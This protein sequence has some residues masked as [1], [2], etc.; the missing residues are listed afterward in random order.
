MLTFKKTLNFLK[1]FLFGFVILTCFLACD[2][3]PVDPLVIVDTD[4]DGIP[5]ATD[6]CPEIFNP[7][8]EDL[9][10]NGI[11]DACEDIVNNDLDDDGILNDDD[12][13]PLVA[14]SGQEDSDNDGIGDACDDVFNLTPLYPCE[15]GMA[16]PYSCNDYDLMGYIPLDELAE[17]G[18]EGNDSWGWTDTTTNKE[19]ALICSTHGTAFVDITNPTAPILLGKLASANPGHSGNVWRDVKTYNN[20]AFIVSE[21]AG[22]GMQVFDLTRLRNVANPPETFTADAHFTEFGSA[23]NI[24]INETS[25]YAYI[26]G[27]NVNSGGPLFINI[28]NPTNPVNEGSFPGYSHDA[29]VVTYNGP[30]PDY[31][32]QEILIGSNANEVV[33]ANV[34]DK[35]NPTTIATATYN[36]IGYVHQGWF[37]EDMNYFILGDELDEQNFGNNT[38]TLVFDFTDLDNPSVH[39]DYNGPTAAIDHNGYVK[40]ND[41]YLSNYSA[42]LRIIDISNISSNT[43]NETG[44]FDTHPENNNASF[45]GAWNVYPYFPSGNIIVSDIERGLFI[46]RKSGT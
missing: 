8:Q 24:V 26:V 41:Y 28:Q 35:N 29:Q 3:E 37:T 22:H 25:G 15:N 38:R 14:N 43:M 9:N 5:D 42:G 1:I 4:D 30:D 10:D 12:N 23:H 7:N 39:M 6:N 31:T 33:I 40:G 13:C 11:G 16:G 27:S 34:T 2:D 19:Y 46:V 36:N 20:Y 45:E 17:P 18:A 32:G 44:F 21:A